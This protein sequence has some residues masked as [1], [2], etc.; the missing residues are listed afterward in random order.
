M[1]NIELMLIELKVY[2]NIVFKNISK[3]ILIIPKI[4][5]DRNCFF[6]QTCFAGSI[7]KYY[8]YYDSK[9][10]GVAYWLR[11]CAT[12]REVSGSIPSGVT[13]DFFRGYRRNHVPLGSTQP[14]KMSTRKIPGSKAGRCVRLTTLPPPSAKRQENPGP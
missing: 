11:Y 14:L 6:L 8:Y 1:K 10:S 7:G 4:Y 12:S 5:V 2:M 13:G 9:G 3:V